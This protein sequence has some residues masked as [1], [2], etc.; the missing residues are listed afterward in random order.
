MAKKTRNRMELREQF[1][2]AE[3]RESEG[4]EA[5]E[6]EEVEE[7]ADEDEDEDEEEE[8]SKAPAGEDE[9]GEEEEED[10]EVVK[11]K[12]KP[13]KAPKAPKAK[14]KPRTRTP[15]VTRMKVVWC[16]FNNSNAQVATYEYPKKKEA[17]DH[18]AKLTGDKKQGHPFFVQP[19]KVPM[20]E[21][22]GE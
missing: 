8:E 5:K 1:D 11:P 21:K 4:E 16:V 14:A 17:H 7:D 12:K 15:K 9:E 3:R 20:E 2:A 22:K 10:E 13:A 6:S 19:V 18:A